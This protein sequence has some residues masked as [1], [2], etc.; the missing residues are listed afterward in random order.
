MTVASLRLPPGPA[1][2]YD[3]SDDLFVWMNENFA[4]YGDL[5]RASIYGGE[6]YVVSNPDHCEH[7]LRWNWR[8]YPRK[9]QVV[10]RI[11]LLL[12]NG[13]I[14]S[15][16]AFWA[17][18]RRMIQP[19]FTK[20]AVIGQSGLIG[21]ANS[22]LL[23]AWSLAAERGAT[24]NV[25][26]SVSLMTLKITLT[27]L[28]GDDYAT[29]APHFS[30]LAEDAG[31]NLAFAEALRAA[32]AVTLR[33]VS[34]RR[35]DETEATDILGQIMQARDRD[36]GAPMS[37]QQ[38]AREVMTLA[39]AGHE[40][41]AGMI[42]W[43]WRLLAEAPEV[44]T[45]VAEELDRQPW[46]EIPEVAA[47]TGY[48]YTRRVIDEVLRLYPPLWLMTRKAADDDALGDFHIP[49]GTEIYIS[50]YLI[51]HSPHLWEAPEVFDPDR[52]ALVRSELGR[53][54][55][56]RH[57][58]ALCPF[59]AGPRNC[60]GEA[61]ARAEIQTHLM[62]FARRLRLSCDDLRPPEISTGMNLLSKH[63]FI[64]RPERRTG[65]GPRP[66]G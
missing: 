38:L 59:G 64:M 52:P 56:D 58:L 25:T 45:R 28:F 10:K 44:Q 31:R 43:M 26:Q 32:R 7:I 41:T 53:T 35:R 65:D 39:V 24:V 60:I 50:P 6:V 37:D 29:A 42:N 8:N 48:A 57:E 3:A 19:A 14:A 51:Q 40:T 5:Y 62:M 17:S 61:F 18:Q 16:G 23:E 49:A 2:P 15:N 55:P 63:D 20:A 11:A 46:G 36:S 13:L 54:E 22:E 9:G 27:A 34:Q 1:E 66:Q 21:R 47:L 33:V 30:V 4:R 12:G